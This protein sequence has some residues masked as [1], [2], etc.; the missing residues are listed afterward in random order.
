MSC[1]LLPSLS[2]RPAIAGLGVILF[3]VSAAA[4]LAQPVVPVILPPE[5]P[6]S[7][8]SES[9]AL[10][11]DHPWATP[12]EASGLTAT[13]RYAETMTWLQRLA[14]ASPELAM[15]SIGKS[16][17]GRDLWLVIASKERAFTPEAV[18]A[19]GKPVLFAQA[20]IHAGEIDGK[21][22]GM[23]LLRDM[24]VVGTKRDLLDMAHV[25]FVPIF[26]V[27]GHERF[28][29][30]TRVNQRGPAEGGWRSNARNL[31]LNRDY[32]KADTAEMRH[33]LTAL[34]R[35]SPDLYVDLHVTDGA[36][37]QY[38]ITFGY[39][40]SA[41]Y[42][43]AIGKWLEDVADPAISNDLRSMGHVPGTLYQVTDRE[44]PS[45]GIFSWWAEPRFS[46]GYGDAIH[47]PTILLE[48]HSLKP[49]RQRVLGTYVFLESTIRLLG[50]E[51][52]DLRALV[53]RD[54]ALRRDTLPLAW[55]RLDAP[56]RTIDMQ[57]VSWEHID[58][59][60]TG[61][62]QLLY[63]GK[64]LSLT[65]PYLEMIKV[66]SRATRP[67]AYLVP[68]AWTE[69]VERLDL[70]GIQF[71]RFET[72]READV[73]MYRIAQPKL[74][75]DPFEGRVMVDATLEVERRTERF[76]AGTVRVSTDQPLGALAMILL[77]PA[78]PDSF[79]RWGFF[80]EVL[81]GTEYIEA[82]IMEPTARR[83]LE[84]D[85]AL[86]AEF[87][88]RLEDPVFASN[89]NAR[90]RFF[91]ERSPYSDDRFRLYPVAREVA[92]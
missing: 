91:Y 65:V 17:E 1:A 47:L 86:R 73:E 30:Y 6:W 52:R 40:T 45:K 37:Y 92:R 67:V 79:F 77:E 16:P 60:I 26:N 4:A 78:G 62:K 56:Q 14:D 24:T 9:L 83:M 51:Y 34:R 15:V 5:L 57:A 46:N 48:N 41:Y 59:P 82:Y 11:P 50:R 85:P 7:G 42:S 44:D 36:D 72:A 43:P 2:T 28:S 21:D 35:W 63:T 69:V 58:S 74:A 27:D 76:P 19:S 32:T 87:E 49:F 13:P 38:D 53:A 10:A 89:P 23:M 88:R 54:R 61:A 18:R 75:A 66:A 12:A 39:N 3:L 71:E 70:H 33:M 29:A 31:N 25:L 84:S 8:K 20:G 81:Q 22:A 64:P 90:L 80:H 68:P 55:V